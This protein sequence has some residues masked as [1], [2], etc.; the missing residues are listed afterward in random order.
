MSLPQRTNQVAPPTSNST[1]NIIM[2]RMILRFLEGFFVAF[3]NSLAEMDAGFSLATFNSPL[4][5][6]KSNA[7]TGF[8]KSSIIAGL[9]DKVSNVFVSSAVGSGAV[10]GD[11]VGLTTGAG[12]LSGRE[13]SNGDFGV[14]SLALTV[15]FEAE[16]LVVDLAFVVVLAFVGVLGVFWVEVFDVV[17][18]AVPLERRGLSPSIDLFFSIVYNYNIWRLS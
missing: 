15:G 5:S 9:A 11:E 2:P 7:W 14:V 18:L 6:S 4:S 13:V 16:D 10:S 3:L 12:A 8:R 17:D 1:I